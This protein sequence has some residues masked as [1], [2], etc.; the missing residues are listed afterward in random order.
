MTAEFVLE[1]ELGATR[2][3]VNEPDTLAEKQ[4][5]DATTPTLVILETAPA[6]RPLTA[7]FETQNVPREAAVC[8]RTKMIPVPIA[9]I[10]RPPVAAALTLEERQHHLEGS[11][12]KKMKYNT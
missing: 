6:S 11:R 10:E 7:V 2:S 1:T 9:V 4:D 3:N 5:P 12:L 8:S